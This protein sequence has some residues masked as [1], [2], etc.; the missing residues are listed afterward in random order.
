MIVFNATDCV[1]LINF[2]NFSFKLVQDML[3]QYNSA[4]CS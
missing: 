2:L 1:K 3:L 4:T